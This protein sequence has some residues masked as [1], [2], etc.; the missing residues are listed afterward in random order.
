VSVSDIT[1]GNLV[2]IFERIAEHQQA[3]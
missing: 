2:K 1:D 3:S